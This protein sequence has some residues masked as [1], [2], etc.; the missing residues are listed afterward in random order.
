M[1]GRNERRP[2]VSAA[3]FA[4]LAL[5]LFLSMFPSLRV[6]SADGEHR[7]ARELLPE[8]TASNAGAI[9]P[10]VPPPI[11]G[12]AS[13]KER[14]TLA[15]DWVSAARGI[16]SRV[17]PGRDAADVLLACAF[18]ERNI[19]TQR[20][21]AAADLA[22][23][24]DAYAAADPFR[25][26]AILELARLELARGHPQAALGYRKSLGRYDRSGGLLGPSTLDQMRETAAR[27]HFDL[28]W[29]RAEAGMLAGIGKL[30]EAG[31]VLER[32]SAR[33]QDPNR[34][35]RRLERA[36]RYYVR[37]SQ[38]AEALAAIDAAS[39]HVPAE[40]RQADL[41]FWR[42]HI[43]HGVID[44][45]G[46]PALLSAWPGD[47]FTQ[48]VLGYLDRYGHL[49]STAEQYLAFGSYAHTANQDEVALEIYRLALAN[50]H[51]EARFRSSASLLAGLLVMVPVAIEL[52]RYD[53]AQRF[54]DAIARMGGGNQELRDVL[55]IRLREARAAGAEP[56]EAARV[57]AEKQAAEKQA[58]Q[59]VA[60]PRAP[61]ELIGHL[62]AD[63]AGQADGDAAEPGGSGDGRSTTRFLL[64]LL[65]PGLLLLCLVWRRLL[66]GR[67]SA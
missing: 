65:V 4:A 16:L 60:M 66:A 20:A 3:I 35:A 6:A 5:C 26:V 50:P 63:A 33:L 11:P 61:G 31:R 52:K 54:L 57:A 25:A 24:R 56:A 49:A 45:N 32:G 22:A 15:L 39:R 9:P 18:L 13:H 14:A 42:L 12:R 2:V 30:S 59:G 44:K 21:Q 55:E 38:P 37:A 64:L 19:D 67:R 46:S 28:Y 36:A 23:A 29:P 34:R 48:R 1:S 47:G 10:H 41:A 7:R 17:E 40:R 62:A 51:L 27:R 43:E 53:E 8:G 58:P